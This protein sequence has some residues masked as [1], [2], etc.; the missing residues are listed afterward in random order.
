MERMKKRYIQLHVLIS[1]EAREIL[2]KYRRSKRVP[3]RFGERELYL[4]EALTEILEKLE[5]KEE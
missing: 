5:V 1:E 4:G 2:E 3:T